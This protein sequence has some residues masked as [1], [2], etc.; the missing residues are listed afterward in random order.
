MTKTFYKCSCGI[1]QSLFILDRA[2]VLISLSEN[3][4]G[5]SKFKNQPR[6]KLT[7]NII[8]EATT[9][10]SSRLTTLSNSIKESET[11]K[12]SLIKSI[13]VDIPTKTIKESKDLISYYIYYNFNNYLPSSVFPKSLKKATK[14]TKRNTG[15]LA[16]SQY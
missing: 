15:L 12:L 14:L 13:Q 5:S 16:F 9:T 10:F 4:E 1:V 8:K 3:N 2:S 7:T 11:G 6:I